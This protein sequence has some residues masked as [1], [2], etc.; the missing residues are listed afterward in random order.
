MQIAQVTNPSIGTL[1]NLVGQGGTGFLGALLSVIVTIILAAGGLYFFFQL[2]TGAVAWI[3]SGGDKA[4]LEGA[5]SKIFNAGIGLV[6]LFSAFAIIT[7]IQ[8]IF[9][10]SILLFDIPTI[11]NVG[12]SSGTGSV[13]VCQG[14]NCSGYGCP[15]NEYCVCRQTPPGPVYCVN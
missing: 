9:G 1:T 3:G 7:L 4:A 12:Q 10:I 14:T 5:R 11:A 15:V 8:N 6:L 2:L 13:I